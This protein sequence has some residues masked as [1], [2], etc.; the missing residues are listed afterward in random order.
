MPTVPPWAATLAL[1]ALAAA[2]TPAPTVALG[3]D[4]DARSAR[5]L[6][7]EAARQGPVRLVLNEVPVPPDRPLTVDRIAADA[8]AGVRGL[9]VR[10]AAAPAEAAGQERLVLV[11]D[12]PPGIRPTLICSD[13]ATVP[14]PEGRVGPPRLHAIFCDG[15]S[16]VADTSGSIDESSADAVER[17]IWRTTARLFPD[18][19]AD[20]Y[21]FDLFGHRIGLGFGGTIS[22]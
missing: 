2:C 6:L 7:A 10:F 16:F 11:F 19:Y 9:G 1:C 17:L 14:A 20:T 15:R 21:G 4:A 18:D 12:P 13:D 22:R 3:R 8:A 5:R